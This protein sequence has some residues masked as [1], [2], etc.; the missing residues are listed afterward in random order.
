VTTDSEREFWMRRLEATGRAQSRYLW[1]LLIAC[2]FYAALFARTVSQ[3]I[4]VP[5][6]D[7]NLDS[8]SVLASGGPV[9]AFLVLAI[10]GAIRAWTHALEQIRGVDSRAG[11]EQLDT[12]PNAIDLAIYTTDK[13]PKTLRSILYFAYPVVLIAALIESVVLWYSVVQTP[14]FP[15]KAAVIILQALI[16]LPAAILVLSMVWSRVSKLKEGSRA[17]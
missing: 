11:A 13:S 3:T 2:L 7:L 14:G 16:W 15:H 10:M 4:T 1:F 9:I 17:A 6:V 12:Y 5:I 8:L